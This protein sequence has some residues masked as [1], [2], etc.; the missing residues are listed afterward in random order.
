MGVVVGVATRVAP[1]YRPFWCGRISRSA[2]VAEGVELTERGS[3]TMGMS[4]SRVGV[5]R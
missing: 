1:D 3:V 2:E 5:F 4:R